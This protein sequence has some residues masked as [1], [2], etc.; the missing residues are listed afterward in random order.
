[1]IKTHK[2]CP[3][4]NTKASK[5]YMLFPAAL[6]TPAMA[7]LVRTPPNS[8][9]MMPMSRMAM[10]KNRAILCL[11][12]VAR[13]KRA[14]GRWNTNEDTTAQ[15]NTPYHISEKSHRDVSLFPQFVAFFLG[16]KFKLR[17]CFTNPIST[18][19]SSCISHRIN[20]AIVREESVKYEKRHL[21]R[22]PRVCF[23]HRCSSVRTNVH[24]KRNAPVTFY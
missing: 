12:S 15:R 7:A 9:P 10:G 22:P 3:T 4:P 13:A 16:T 17:I 1:M 6:Q 20:T 5:E 21:K 8:G 24:Y 19:Q 11:R 23:Q 2:D 14:A 18:L